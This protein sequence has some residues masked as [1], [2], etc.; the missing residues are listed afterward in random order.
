[1]NT[2][3]KRKKSLQNV[4]NTSL[5]EHPSMIDSFYLMNRFKTNKEKA[6]HKINN[7]EN[8]K[9]N[10][11]DALQNAYNSL[12]NVPGFKTNYNDFCDWMYKEYTSNVVKPKI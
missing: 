5:D 9:L 6:K 4:L 3:S 1:M 7:Y 12:V 10:N 11:N 8:W 2:D